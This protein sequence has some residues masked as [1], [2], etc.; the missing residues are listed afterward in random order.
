MRQSEFPKNNTGSL[1]FHF[2]AVT[3]VNCRADVAN[4]CW[5]EANGNAIDSEASFSLR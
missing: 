2:H 5:Y 1:G 4:A 3:Q